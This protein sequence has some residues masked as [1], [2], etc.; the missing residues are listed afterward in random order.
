M[1]EAATDGFAEE[2]KIGAGGFGG[3]YKATGLVVGSNQCFAVKR[4]DERSLQGLPEVLR[5]VQVLGGCLHQNVLPLFGFSFDQVFCVVTVIM[6]GGCLQDRMFPDAEGASRR[7]ELVGAGARPAA[8]VWTV[9]LQVAAEVAAGLEYLHTPDAATHKPAILHRDLKPANVLL[10]AD[11]KA[12]LGDAGLARVRPDGQA[13]LSV[14]LAGTFGFMDPNYMHTGQFDESCDGYALGVT[15]LMLLTGRPERDGGGTLVN[16]CTG[17]NANVLADASCQWPP[18]VAQ[19]MLEVARALVVLDRGSRI[20]VADARRRLE[21]LA[22]ADQ[23]DALPGKRPRGRSRRQRE[24]EKAR[25]EREEA[26]RERERE[27]RKRDGV[28]S[29]GR[30]R[31]RR[32]ARWSGSA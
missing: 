31:G 14:T 27:E 18:N 22:P 12:R 25:R 10:D 3:V 13:H 17:H 11:L 1:L 6:C 8:L 29:D 9:R 2:R 16:L 21:A 19:G 30:G 20:S 7:L 4:L 32:A 23:V 15:L 26:E 28:S 24:K 5:E